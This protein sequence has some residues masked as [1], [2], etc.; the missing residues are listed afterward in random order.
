MAVN[1]SGNFASWAAFG[2]KQLIY[3]DYISRKTRVHEL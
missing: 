3:F 1:D 2:R